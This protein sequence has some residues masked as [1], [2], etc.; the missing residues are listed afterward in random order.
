MNIFLSSPYP[1]IQAPM[2]GAQGVDMAVAVCRGGGVGSL[3]AALLSA[4]ALEKAIKTIQAETDAVFNVNFFAHQMPTE[5]VEDKARWQQLLSPYFDEYQI[6]AKTIDSGDLR[7]P[8]GKEQLAVL[9]NQPV[10]IVSFH[11]GLPDTQAVA[12]IKA[13]GAKVLATATTL[14]EALWL[15]SNG[16]DAII[17]QGYE[18][19]GHRGLFLHSQSQTQVGL[20]AL[21]MQIKQKVKLPLIAAGGISG[22]NAIQATLA[23]GADAVQIGTAYLLCHESQISALHRDALEQAVKNPETAETAISNLFSG[24]PARGLVNRLMQ[25]QG[26]IHPDVAPF[27]YAANEINALRKKAE[28]LGK[29]DFTP[30]WCGQNLSGCQNKSAET[31][32]RYWCENVWPSP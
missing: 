13:T 9:E 4:K 17:V 20:F 31:L 18:A 3:P 19:G 8:F 14:A 25:E 22:I 30:L 10:G 1:L 28:A 23:M 11:F 15:E 24:R 2:A 7:Q 5:K 27:P 6:D 29:N 26:F 12:R 16:A 21:L 32:T